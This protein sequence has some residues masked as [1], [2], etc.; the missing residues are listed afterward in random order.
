[1][2]LWLLLFVTLL[3]RPALAIARVCDEVAFAIVESEIQN[4]P[5]LSRPALVFTGKDVSEI[6]S[7]LFPAIRDPRALVLLQEILEQ[8]TGLVLMPE[9]RG[10]AR[11][12]TAKHV[13]AEFLAEAGFPSPR[14]REWLLLGTECDYFALFHEKVH[15]DDAK[16]RET[17]NW[18]VSA[19]LTREQ[20]KLTEFYQRKAGLAIL[21]FIAEQR[22]ETKEREERLREGAAL[23][24][25]RMGLLEKDAGEL[26]G[27]LT[28]F[29][30]T[31]ES[32]YRETLAILRAHTLPGDFSLATL[33]P[34]H[35]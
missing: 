5:E 20:S 15:L 7:R 14:S 19:L 13:Y 33:L 26:S 30:L 35:F 25:G 8:G 12:V 11:V 21:N 3:P 16:L 10:A 4:Y 2:K 22:A 32:L 28:V 34:E 17:A 29:Q 18:E 9:L 24:P 6:P 23:D 1:M 27:Y 31:S